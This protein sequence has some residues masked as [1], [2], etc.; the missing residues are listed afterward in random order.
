MRERSRMP[1]RR[2]KDGGRLHVGSDRKG[3]HRR[4]ETIEGC[5]VLEGTWF[6]EHPPGITWWRCSSAMGKVGNRMSRMMT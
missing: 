6:S 4:P 5:L 1:E 3:N 2:E